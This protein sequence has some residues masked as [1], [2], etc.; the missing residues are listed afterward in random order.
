VNERQPVVRFEPPA[1]RLYRFA[2]LGVEGIDRDESGKPERA[3]LHV[4]PKSAEGISSDVPI[5]VGP[6]DRLQVADLLKQFSEQGFTAIELQE[7][8]GKVHRMDVPRSRRS[9]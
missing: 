7:S 5:T 4:I 3:L 8:P 9:R 1:Q 6:I 2:Q